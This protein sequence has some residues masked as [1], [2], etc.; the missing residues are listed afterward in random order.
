V[1]AVAEG[2]DQ[3]RRGE[4][5]NLAEARAAVV[6]G[7]EAFEI[8]GGRGV[9]DR[10]HR[11]DEGIGVD[12]VGARAVV[13]LDRLHDAPERD[14]ALGHADRFVSGALEQLGVAVADAVL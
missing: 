13:D 1:A 7:I 6:L 12:A 11:R 4:S 3:L 2:A 14:R 8:G 9:G 5:G 10:E